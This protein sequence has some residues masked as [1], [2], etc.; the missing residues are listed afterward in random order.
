MANST[1]DTPDVSETKLAALK[2]DELRAHAR[3]LGIDGADELHKPE[4]LAKVKDYHY[5][6]AHGGKHRDGSGAG[7]ST[8]GRPS[9]SELSSMK[10]GEL[11][12]HARKHGIDGADELHKPELL[13]K[14]KDYHYAQAHGGKDR[15][16]SGSGSPTTSHRSASE[17]SSMKLGELREHARKLGIDGA[18]ELHK[19]ELLAKVKDHHDTNSGDRGATAAKTNRGG[20]STPDT[21]EVSETKLA[22]LKMD[23]LRSHARKLGIDGADELHK[24]EL[25]AKVKDHHYAQAHGGKHRPDSGSGSTGGAGGPS[26]V[27]EDRGGHSTP[28]AQEANKT[29]LGTASTDTPQDRPSS[30]AL[31]SPALPSPALHSSEVDEADEPAQPELHATVADA[32]NPTEDEHLFPLKEKRPDLDHTAATTQAVTKT[33]ETAET[34]GTDDEGHVIAESTN[35]ALTLPPGRLDVGTEARESGPARLPE[36]VGSGHQQVTAPESIEEVDVDR[37][38]TT[39]SIHGVADDDQAIFVKQPE[40]VRPEVMLPDELSVVD[41]TAV[42]KDRNLLDTRIRTA[43]QGEPDLQEARPRHGG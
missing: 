39:E 29:A 43:P 11:R 12:E 16:G 14:V 24:P 15:D 25:L 22:A 9:A 21:P 26:P 2:M 5:A 8:D 6:Q 3:K 7:S 10:L 20:N 19:P 38:P 33:A 23:E 4:L 40:R 34:T 18:D 27:K 37:E 1:P 17:L 35:D 28:D 30:P 32:P 42:L 13:A 36:R 41:P 31:P